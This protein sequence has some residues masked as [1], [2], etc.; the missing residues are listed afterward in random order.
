MKIQDIAPCGLNC[1]LCLAFQRTTNNC[2]GCN[3]PTERIPKHC[4]TC[5]IRNCEEKA[6]NTK[7][8]CMECEKFP[9]RR[10]KDLDKRYSGRYQVHLFENFKTIKEHGIREFIKREK[11]KWQCPACGKTLCMHREKCLNCGS[12][13]PEFSP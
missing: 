13:K 8:L 9:C 12:P 3:G 10:L 2:H 4:L 5:K 11:G 7:Q 6:G 1:H